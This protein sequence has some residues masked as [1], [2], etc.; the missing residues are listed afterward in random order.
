MNNYELDNIISTDSN[1][2]GG[3]KLGIKGLKSMGMRNLAGSVVGTFFNPF[4]LS[5][6]MYTVVMILCAMIYYGNKFMK[7]SGFPSFSI[8]CSQ[9][10]LLL[11]LTAIMSGLCIFNKIA[12]WGL[13]IVTIFVMI[14][15]TYFSFS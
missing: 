14:I 10:V 6:K 12:G 4:C 5:M 13:A 1:L 9:I 3:K 8:C 2:W 11:V 15:F 7:G